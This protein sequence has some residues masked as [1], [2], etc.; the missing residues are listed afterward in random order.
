MAGSSVQDLT[1][2]RPRC[3]F[4]CILTQRQGLP[5][6]SLVVGRIQLLV[7]DCG[8]DVPAFLLAASQE[9]VSALKS[10]C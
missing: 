3:Q 2:L 7:A 4:D 8:T 9:M 6:G 5:P 1:Q 10:C